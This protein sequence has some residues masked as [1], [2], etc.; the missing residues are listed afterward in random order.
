MDKKRLALKKALL[1]AKANIKLHP[2]IDKNKL[3]SSGGNIGRNDWIFFRISNTSRVRLT[4]SENASLLLVKNGPDT[5]NIQDL[6][7]NEIILNNVTIEQILS[8]APEQLFFLLYKN[9]YNNCQF[10]P[11]T[12]NIAE[13]GHYSWGDMYKR[14]SENEQFNIR[15]I[16]VTTSSPPDKTNE[17]LV[18]EMVDVTN[19]I[20]KIKGNDIPIGMS[21]KT[22]T[23][24]QLCRLKEAGVSEMRLNL[25]TYNPELAKT[26]MPRKKINE[27]LKS[28][29]FAV[30]VFG[31]EKVS[32]N[33]IIG[34]GETDNDILQGVEVLS[35]MGALSSLYPYDPIDL[36]HE[37]FKRP[38][39]PIVL[40]NEKFKRPSA[41]RIFNLAVEHKKIL[42]NHNLNP[43]GAK[44]MCCS[45]AASHLYPGKDI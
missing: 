19:K 35:E 21:L 29:E 33:I 14:I 44:T 37:K 39:V 36:T 42:E 5:Y 24:D 26:L 31:K 6:N 41:E 1:L 20:R 16:S 8:H 40:P 32:S 3:D 28:I 18:N 12:Y 22:P 7:T 9:C 13:K 25:E 43:L 4:L 45:C 17:D 30:E 15:S 10:C 34:L 23:K 38:S 27:I 2:D 11:M